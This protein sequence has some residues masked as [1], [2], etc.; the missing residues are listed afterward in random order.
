MALTKKIRFEVFKRDSFTCQYCGRQAPDVVLN[1][2]HISPVA[3]GGDDD[4]LN[5]VTSCFDCNSGKS[6]RTL[7]DAM[8]LAK[9]KAQLDDLQERRTQLGM[10]MD[11]QRGL[12][13]LKEEVVTQ[14]HGFWRERVPGSCLNERGLA[15]L[16]KLVKKYAPNIIMAALADACEQHLTTDDEGNAT[17]ESA[18]AVWNTTVKF[19]GIKSDEVHAPWLKDAFYIRG[20]VRNRMSYYNPHEAIR[21]IKVAFENGAD[22]EYLKDIAKCENSWSAWV[23]AMNHLDQ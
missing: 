3:K 12:L 7:D 19:A 22:A 2:D 17:R 5:L 11:W 16:R 14:L 23:D 18:D 10:L 8:V 4:I 20:I 6:D 1:C 13:D 9:R 15:E 21:L